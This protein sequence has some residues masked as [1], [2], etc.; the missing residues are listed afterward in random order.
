VFESRYVE[1]QKTLGLPKSYDPPKEFQLPD[2]TQ[3]IQ[4]ASPPDSPDIYRRVRDGKRKRQ[5]PKVNQKPPKTKKIEPIVK[6]TISEKKA[7]FD[8]LTTL[9]DNEWAMG[10]LLDIISPDETMVQTGELE[11]DVASLPAP[12]IRKI[13]RFIKEHID[14]NFKTT[15]TDSSEDYIILFPDD[16]W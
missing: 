14:D 3:V 5:Y 16:D 12:T 8:M 2:F 7:L 6:V 15:D 9:S 4:S 1:L 13:Q 11:I 10:K